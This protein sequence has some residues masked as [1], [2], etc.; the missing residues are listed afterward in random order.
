MNYR[1]IYHAGNFGDVL[2][3]IVLIAILQSLQRKE[4]P[5]CFLDTH[6]GIATYDL[7]SDDAKKTSEAN[8]GVLRLLQSQGPAPPLVQDYLRC[9]ASYNTENNFRIYP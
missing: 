3:H 1:H 4:T 2:K 8:Q 6:A 7:Q 9:F 5:F